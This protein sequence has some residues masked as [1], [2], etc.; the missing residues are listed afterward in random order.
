M[1]KVRAQES[2]RTSFSA[3]PPPIHRVILSKADWQWLAGWFRLGKSDRRKD[4]RNAP[5]HR[6]DDRLSDFGHLTILAYQAGH[7]GGAWSAAQ[8]AILR[9]NNQ[10]SR[11]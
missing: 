3:C 2:V 7:A 6:H 8:A 4:P 5:R 10:G 9:K 1:K 11:S